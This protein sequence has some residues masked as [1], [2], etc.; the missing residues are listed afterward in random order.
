VPELPLGAHPLGR[1]LETALWWHDGEMNLGRRV[2]L[3]LALAAAF[4]VIAATVSQIVVEPPSGGW[5]MYSPNGDNV[6]FV[7]GDSD[8]DAL[9]VAAIWLVAI[10][11]W[12]GIAWRRFRGRDE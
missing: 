9:R 7:P 1:Q 10:G 12:F 2:V 6:P 3:L 11:A 5:F 8:V 4:G